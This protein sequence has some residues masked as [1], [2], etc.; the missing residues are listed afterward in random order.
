MSIETK[1]PNGPS[2]VSLIVALKYIFLVTGGIVLWFASSSALSFGLNNLQ[3]FLYQR[4]GEVLY[5]GGGLS[6]LLFLGTIF[7]PIAVYCL[8]S[9]RFFPNH[10][11]MVSKNDYIPPKQMGSLDKFCVVMAVL[12]TAGSVLSFNRYLALGENY[13]VFSQAGIIPERQYYSYNDVRIELEKDKSIN[14]YVPRFYLKDKMLA[15]GFWDDRKVAKDIQEH[16]NRLAFN[17]PYISVEPVVTSHKRALASYIGIIIMGICI[18]VF[19]RIF[20]KRK[21]HG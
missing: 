8:I 16:R 13:V 5:V 14:E 7:V 2:Q 10:W 9:I 17:A 19:S 18:G 15:M 11:K 6:I 3:I 1:K 20:V 21:K 4:P 12:C